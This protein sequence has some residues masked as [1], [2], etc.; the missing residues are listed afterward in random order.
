MRKR[1]KRKPYTNFEESLIGNEATYYTYL[2]RLTELAIS[3][4]IWLNMPDT[5]NKR[6]V[7]LQLFLSGTMVFF[8]DEYLGYLCLNGIAQ[9]QFDVYGYPIRR[10][11][12]SIYNNYNVELDD[13]DSVMIFNNLLRTNSVRDIR[14]F[15]NR[16]Y[17][18]DRIIDI[19]A[20]AQKTPVLILADEKERLTLKNVY[21]QY[22]G[23][24][25]V[26]YGDK[27]LDKKA[28]TVLKTDAPYI[29]DKI[30]EL[31]C[32]IWNEALTY[33]GISNIT[34]NKK[35]RLITDEVER[36]QGGV[37]GNRFPYLNAR[38]E[39]CE[40]INNMFGLD[41]DVMF[42]EDWGEFDLDL[43]NAKKEEKV[44]DENG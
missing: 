16:L 24:Q 7:E 11:A 21:M 43:P 36:N 19:N 39:A 6:Y 15:A 41:V 20:N 4:I 17:N 5:V 32:N 28:V 27:S 18:L 12:Y 9:G 34:V 40:Q 26:I 31:K 42:R 29:A 23:N 10:R 30:Y 13:T 35:E 25:P 37:I 38:Q 22:D 1:S 33:L 44:G 3:R 2:D 8:K 14:I